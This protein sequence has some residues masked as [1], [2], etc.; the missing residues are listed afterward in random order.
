MAFH[1]RVA[2]IAEDWG[3]REGGKD[4]KQL[5]KKKQEAVTKRENR[6]KIKQEGESSR[7]SDESGKDNGVLKGMKWEWDEREMQQNR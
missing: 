3:A 4:E 1:F 6:A 7:K 2:L 5:E